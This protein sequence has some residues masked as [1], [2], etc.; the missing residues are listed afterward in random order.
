[1]LGNFSGTLSQGKNKE[2]RQLCQLYTTSHF[3]GKGLG[4]GQMQPEIKYRIL[5]TA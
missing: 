1:M 5:L 3:T 4:Q 2:L